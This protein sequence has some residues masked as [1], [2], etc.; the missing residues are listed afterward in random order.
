MMQALKRKS[1][2]VVR[3]ESVRR[4]NSK[5]RVIDVKMNKNIYVCVCEIMIVSIQSNNLSHKD[6]RP[7]GGAQTAAPKQRRPNGG[8]QMA[9]LKRPVQEKR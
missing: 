8:A 1:H 6:R 4:R 3:V 9:A 5:A 7:I 2:S